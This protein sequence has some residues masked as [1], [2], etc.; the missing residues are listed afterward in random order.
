MNNKLPGSVQRYLKTLQQSDRSVAYVCLDFNNL[1]LSTGGD[2]AKCGMVN[3]ENGK[4]IHA[5]LPLLAQLVPV[6]EKPV[7]IA[8]TQINECTIIDLH[9]F[10]DSDA[11]WIVIF[12]NTEAGIQLQSEQQKRLTN[13]IIEEQHSRKSG[14]Q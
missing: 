2:L 6:S 1:I 13:D 12:D 11:Q 10:A 4:S 8:N 3:I 14:T 7:I 5:Q 9:L